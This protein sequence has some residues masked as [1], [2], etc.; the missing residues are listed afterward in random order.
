MIKVCRI[1]VDTGRKQEVSVSSKTTTCYI[2]FV[3]ELFFYNLVID[4]IYMASSSL[5]HKVQP[6]QGIGRIEEAMCRCETQGA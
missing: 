1:G 4:L 3:I 5:S 6:Q 2:I